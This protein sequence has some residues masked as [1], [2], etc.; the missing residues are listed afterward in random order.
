[1]QNKANFRKSQM[2]VT[3]VL[4]KNYEKR[5]LGGVG[6]TKPIQ[7]QTKP[8]KANLPDAQNERK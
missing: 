7:S 1:M 4:T 2:N 5:T 3:Y 6:K 8:I